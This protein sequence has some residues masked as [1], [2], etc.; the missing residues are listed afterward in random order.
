MMRIEDLVA[1]L[2]AG[3][4]DPYLVLSD[5][6]LAV[7]TDEVPAEQRL[8]DTPSVDELDEAAR[9]AALAAAARGL[10]ARGLVVADPQPQDSSEPQVVVLA[11]LAVVLDLLSQ[12]DVTVVAQRQDDGGTHLLHWIGWRDQVV[13][14]HEARDGLHRFALRLPGRAAAALAAFAD[15]DG[16]A[17]DEGDHRPPVVAPADLRPTDTDGAE[18]VALLQQPRAS[19]QVAAAHHDRDELREVILAATDQGVWLVADDAEAMDP[20]HLRAQELSA[21]SLL[22][23]ACRLVGFEPEPA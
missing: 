9:R 10:V 5:E 23:V 6:E 8:F 15:P 12:P 22:G 14:E 13:L 16:L 3:D 1:Q 18:V 7:V 21:L 17:R 2:E 20:P 11:E 19:T 4:H